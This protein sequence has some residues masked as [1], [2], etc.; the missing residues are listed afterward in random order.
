MSQTK[1]WQYCSLYSQS[2]QSRVFVPKSFDITQKCVFDAMHCQN[3]RFGMNEENSG[4]DGL[5]SRPIRQPIK[6]I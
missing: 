5:Q 3:E 6:G 1:K 2:N 4:L